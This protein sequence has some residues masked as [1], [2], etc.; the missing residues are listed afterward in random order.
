MS[1]LF[2]IFN[3]I[4]SSSIHRRGDPAACAGTVIDYILEV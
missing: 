1:W 2:G 3:R 4:E